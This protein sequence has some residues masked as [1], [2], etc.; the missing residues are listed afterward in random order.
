[1][2]RCYAAITAQAGFFVSYF[3]RSSDWALVVT[4]KQLMLTMPLCLG[5]A[6]NI[7]LDAF[8]ND[9]YGLI[10]P[11]ALLSAGEG[12]EGRE[13]STRDATGKQAQPVTAGT[14]SSVTESDDHED[15]VPSLFLRNLTQVLDSP[16]FS[17]TDH[18]RSAAHL[19]VHRL[20]SF[21]TRLVISTLFYPPTLA[22]R[23]STTSVV[24][25][26]LT[27]IHNLLSRHPTLGL[28]AFLTSID[29]VTSNSVSSSFSQAIAIGEDSLPLHN[30]LTSAG[31]AWYPLLALL[32]HPDPRVRALAQKLATFSSS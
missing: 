16:S 30:P 11:V 21:S 24:L 1:M 32:Q 25:E 31:C 12:W 4:L 26:I 17:S 28:D 18:E 22:C 20:A 19:P 8:I 14:S 23:N 2:I 29:R 6:L 10:F 27:L 5:E 3:P 9:L 7:S 13:S 15:P